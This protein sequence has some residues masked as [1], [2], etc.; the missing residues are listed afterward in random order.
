[1]PASTPVTLPGPTTRLSASGWSAGKK[2]G[3]P[4]MWSQ[5]RW[6]S[7]M[8]QRNSGCR[9]SDLARL[10]MPVPASRMSIGSSPHSIETQGV[11]PPYRSTPCPDTGIEP[12]VP[13]M[14][15]RNYGPAGSSWFAST[16]PLQPLS[17]STRAESPERSIRRTSVPGLQ[18]RRRRPRG[19]CGS[20]GCRARRPDSMCR[21]PSRR[22]YLA[23]LDRA[24]DRVGRSGTSGR[25]IGWGDRRGCGGCSCRRRG[26]GS[27][28]RRGGRGGCGSSSRG[29]RGRRWR[30]DGCRRRRRRDGGGGGLGR[31]G[32][33]EGDRGPASCGGVVR[34]R[35]ARRRLLHLLHG[36]R[37]RRAGRDAGPS[38]V[39]DEEGAGHHREVVAFR[40]GLRRCG[41]E[42]LSGQLEHHAVGERGG[43]SR[44]A[45]CAR[46][47]PPRRMNHLRRSRAA[48]VHSRSGQPAQPRRCRS[49]AG[50]T[51]WQHRLGS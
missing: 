13:Q 34:G 3:S 38:A 47:S 19:V 20:A 45:G 32:D 17:A 21:R 22:R 9:P 23:L 28:G 4:I 7:A 33:L 36:R 5:C 50:R 2:N 43:P 30:C 24:L 31:G 41:D 6:V 40:R 46:G 37:L 16:Q 29:S 27:H 14:W 11:L 42:V 51:R 18:R 15:R 48:C 35:R 44:C 26:R 8:V 25:A 1:M 49:S 39:G 12:R 10:K